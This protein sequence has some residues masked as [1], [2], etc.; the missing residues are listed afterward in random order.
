[1]MAGVPESLMRIPQIAVV[2]GLVDGIVAGLVPREILL[3]LPNRRCLCP[4]LSWVRRYL[5]VSAV[6]CPAMSKKKRPF[7]SPFRLRS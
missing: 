5:V 3:V 6:S 1:M 7:P 4:R 2:V